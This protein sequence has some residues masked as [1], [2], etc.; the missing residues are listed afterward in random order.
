MATGLHAPD[1][2]AKAK[3]LNNNNAKSSLNIA[4]QYTEQY[5]WS[6]HFSKIILNNK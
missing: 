5:K 2:E 4:S 1:L 3:Q 6:L